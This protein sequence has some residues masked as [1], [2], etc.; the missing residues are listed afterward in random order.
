MIEL[1]YNLSS[2]WNAKVQRVDWA[3]AD[4]MTLRYRAFL[5][6]QVFIVNGSDF[7]A[8]WGWVPILDF[9]AGLVAATRGLAAGVTEL[10]FEF[11]DSDAHLQFNRQGSN[12]LVT[13][14]YN[15]A[16][17]TVPTNELLQ[18]ANSYAERVLRDAISLNPALKANQSLRSWYPTLT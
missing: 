10:V 1:A 17:A 8:K 5:G 13:S 16:I 14:S 2:S 18:A 12:T 3:N 9:A 15:N 7:S 6:D 4:E 11:T